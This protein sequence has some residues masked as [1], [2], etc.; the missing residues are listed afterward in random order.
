VDDNQ[1]LGK[2]QLYDFFSYYLTAKEGL[3]FDL[4]ER[5]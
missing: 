4:L 5:T 3:P 2:K 1:P